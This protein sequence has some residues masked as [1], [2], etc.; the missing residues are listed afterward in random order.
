[1]MTHPHPASDASHKA[2]LAAKRTLLLVLAIGFTH[3]AFA[4]QGT[5]LSQTAIATPRLTR[6]GAEALAWSQ[7]RGPNG[8]GVAATDCKPP[9]KLEASQV[10]WKTSIPPGRSS[11]ILA[12]DRIFLTGLDQNRLVTLAID[13]A[14]GKVLWRREAPEVAVEKVHPTSS[15]AA[16][17]PL[18]D[19]RWVYV[20]FGSFGLLG[21]D[22]AGKLQWTK[23]L[24]PPKNQYG[25]ATSPIA[26]EGKLILVLDSDENLPDSKLSQSKLVAFQQS[27]GEP[28]WETARPFVR[29]GWSTPAIWEHAGGKELVVLG[30]GC[31]ASYDPTT[32]AEKWRATGFSKETIAVPVMGNGFVYL[33]SAQLGGVPDEKINPQPFWEAVMRFD[34]NGDGKLD[35]SEMTGHFTFPLRP[36]LPPEH[37]GYGI[38]MPD[39]PD[40]RKGRLDGMFGWVDKDKDGFWTR[41]EFAANMAVRQG[42]PTLM[43]IRPG[44]EGDVTGS[45]VAW[46]LHRNIPEIPS[47]IFYNNRLYLVRN[48]GILAAVEAANG[49]VLYSER[50]G[51]AGQYSASPVAA[52]GHL[53]LASNRGQ[54]SVIKAGD[55]FDLVHQ[56]DL[57]EPVFVT[58]AI[59][60]STLYVRTETELWAFRARD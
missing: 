30:S 47:P 45:H 52:N 39:E 19:G 13:R 1:M 4:Q 44:G 18:A 60:K 36:E 58:P 2:K 55:S 42:K 25:M 22:H 31:V 21:Y 28:A 48:G 38:P 16:S 11:P 46:E 26:Y 33:S 9:V 15:P 41:E 24:P 37:P 10:V 17:T 3:P 56:Y 40:A 20:Y 53:Y 32:G 29:S 50:L 12:G 57:G 6:T 59:D 51:S 27:T 14:S 7:F 34:G 23:P 54:L 8:S 49:N 35:R 5:R 43:A